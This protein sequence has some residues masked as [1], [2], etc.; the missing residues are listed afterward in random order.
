MPWFP[1]PWGHLWLPFMCTMC[2]SPSSHCRPPPCLASLPTC[3]CPSSCVPTCRALLPSVLVC[4]CEQLLWV[5][6]GGER[7]FLPERA[8]YVNFYQV[9]EHY[10]AWT[11]VS[12]VC[13][14]RPRA[15]WGADPGSGCSV[16]GLYPPWC[17]QQ[18]ASPPFLGQGGGAGVVWPW[19]GSSWGPAS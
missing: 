3:P 17:V 18:L 13:G 16:M 4:V 5:W 8:V 6:E 2:A 9:P 7:Q 14:V 19:G 1:A 15:G 12:D 10:R 11:T